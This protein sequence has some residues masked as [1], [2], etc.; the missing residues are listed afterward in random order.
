M[1]FYYSPGACSTATHIAL[2]EAGLNFEKEKVNLSEKTCGT[3]DYTKINAKGYVPAL[4][5][6]NNEVLTEGVVLMQWI[7]DQKPESNLLPKYGTMERYKAMEWL[8]YIATEIHKTYSPMFGIKKITNNTEAQADINTYYTNKLYKHF[9]YLTDKLGNNDYL[10]G[11][12]FTVA[13]AYL[14]TCLSWNKY[15]NVELSKWPKLDAYVTR[16]Y[17]RDSVQK[18]LSAEGLLK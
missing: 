17:K 3:G 12:T 9:D 13:D 16:I 15:V 8:N 5:L 1:K 4:K 18:T 14:F 6:D 10:M 7:A 11:S 2:N